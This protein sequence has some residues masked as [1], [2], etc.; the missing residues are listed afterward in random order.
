MYDLDPKLSQFLKNKKVA[1]VGPSPHLIGKGIGKIIDSYDVVCRINE[2]HPTGFE[3]DYGNKTDVVFHNCATVHVPQ[4]INILEKAPPGIAENLKYVIC[5]C[6]KAAG[7]DNNWSTWSDEYISPVVSNFH[8]INKYNTPFYWIGMKN[9][10]FVYNQIFGVEPNA[11]QTAIIIL[12]SHMVKELFITG[13]SFYAQGD[14]PIQ[15]TRPGHVEKKLE[16]E[17]V[18]NAGHPQ[19]PQK[20]AFKNKVFKEYN[21]SIIV[22]SYLNELLDLKHDRIVKL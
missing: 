4:F 12:L 2:V 22:D 16:N 9:Y 6:V 13:F 19:G 14:S 10:R 8:N 3:E 20:N 17:L 15:S 1:I 18:G 21:N 7:S 11:G 5:P